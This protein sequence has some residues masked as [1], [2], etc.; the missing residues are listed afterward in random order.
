MACS[1]CLVPTRCKVKPTSSL[2]LLVA[3]DSADDVVNLP[4]DAIRGPLCVALG[5]RGLVLGLA[6]GVL[7]L[8]RLLP[9]LSTGEVADSLDRSALHGLVL[10]RGFAGACTMSVRDGT[11]HRSRR[12]YLGSVLE[13]MISMASGG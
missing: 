11:M 12:T 13:D 9:G 10:A 7:L 8:A 5:L 1:E 3:L 2:L 6:L 4:S